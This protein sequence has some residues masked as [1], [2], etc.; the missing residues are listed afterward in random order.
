MPPSCRGGTRARHR[1]RSAAAA[2]SP[3]RASCVPNA[4]AC[5][6][7]KRVSIRRSSARISEP[8]MVTR[9]ASDAARRDPVGSLRRQ[10]AEDRTPL[11]PA[12]RRSAASSTLA[13][14][15]ATTRMV[16]AT[17]SA[18][19][20]LRRQRN[21]R[22]GILPVRRHQAGRQRRQER[23][24]DG[25]VVGQRHHQVRGA[26][27]GDQAGTRAAARGQQVADLLLG[28]L[29]TR[30]ARRRSGSS[31]RS[32]RAR[33]SKA[34]CP[35]RRAAVR[36]ARSV[37]PRRRCRARERLRPDRSGSM[38]HR[39]GG[40]TIEV[41]QEMRRDHAAPLHVAGVRRHSDQQPRS[42]RPARARA[43]TAGAADGTGLSAASGMKH[44]RSFA[45]H[46]RRGSKTEPQ[47]QAQQH[48]RTERP[49]EQ[50]Q[51]RTP[52]LDSLSLAGAS[53]SMSA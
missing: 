25:A 17:G 38:L 13:R 4:S 43:A 28:A 14:S 3:R 34:P 12:A 1:T 53:R 27:I 16:P 39:L 22:H 2:N 23:L 45:V 8:S 30:S 10:H 31:T 5:A 29:E 18:A 11:R 21:S 49:L 46:A 42:R 15:S 9:T 50:R 7:W 33:S 41:L 32:R 36:A 35:R 51:L 19:S 52:R 48:G 20:V 6:A 44:R 24:D 26:C 40:F 47:R 37:P